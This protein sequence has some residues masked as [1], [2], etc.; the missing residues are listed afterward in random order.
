MTGSVLPSARQPLAP[1]VDN[2]LSLRLTGG[3]RWG[4][5]AFRILAWLFAGGVAVQVF[6]AGLG[7]FAGPE[8]WSAHTTFVH[9][10]EVLPVLMLIAAFIGR[11]PAPAKWL[12]LA[13]FLL[14][15]LQ[16]ALVA[17]DLPEVTAFHPVNALLIF[18]L[19]ISLARWPDRGP[20]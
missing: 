14:I 1:A 13:A 11:L 20:R 6:F 19:A 7:I 2:D 18:W 5:L 10:V 9:L 17:L 8:W 4:R 3:V 12:S 16:Y 15:G